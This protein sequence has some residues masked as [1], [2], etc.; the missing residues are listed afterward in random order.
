M[1]GARRFR[2]ACRVF[3]YAT[4]GV[5][6]RPTTADGRRRRCAPP[7]VRHSLLVGIKPAPV[8]SPPC[9][10]VCMDGCYTQDSSR[11]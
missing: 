7:A 2:A 9:D 3:E 10:Q 11:L 4:P 6:N 1:P 8:R 5:C